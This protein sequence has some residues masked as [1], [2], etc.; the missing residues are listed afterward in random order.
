M[1][2]VDVSR[3]QPIGDKQDHSSRGR[4]G[5]AEKLRAHSLLR[6]MLVHR[7]A[8]ESSEYGH[9]WDYVGRLRQAW[10]DALSQVFELE[11]CLSEIISYVPENAD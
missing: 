5:V 9:P 6:Q 2:F 10:A 1:L 7:V 8:F 4:P 3:D 11:G